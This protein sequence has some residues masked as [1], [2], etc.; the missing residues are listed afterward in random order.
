MILFGFIFNGHNLDFL[1]GSGSTSVVVFIIEEIDFLSSEDA[2]HLCTNVF[3][4]VD[5]IFV[6]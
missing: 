2:D 3:D 5:D 6:S 1:F 4:D